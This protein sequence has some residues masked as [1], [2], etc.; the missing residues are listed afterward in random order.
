MAGVNEMRCGKEPSTYFESPRSSD[1][2]D[3]LRPCFRGHLLDLLVGGDLLFQRGH[4]TQYLFSL[5]PFRPPFFTGPLFSF[6]PRPLPLF[7]ASTRLIHSSASPA[8]GLTFG[9]ATLLVAFSMWRFCFQN[10]SISAGILF[11]WCSRPTGRIG[12][13]DVCAARDDI[14]SF[15][16]AD[17][18][19]G[20]GGFGRLRTPYAH[21]PH[22][23]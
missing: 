10:A 23:A 3:F 19:V 4:K 17:L 5:P 13:A 2:D 11:E 8:L 16:D 7:P 1:R 18:C 6:L 20:S 21:F 15:A 14:S 22:V 9:D 12:R